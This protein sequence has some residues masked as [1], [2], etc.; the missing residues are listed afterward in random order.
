MHKNL[1][2]EVRN[3]LYNKTRQLQATF[4][5]WDSSLRRSAEALNQE[6]EED[7]NDSDSKSNGGSSSAK[8]SDIST[9]SSSKQLSKTERVV[10]IQ[11]WYLQEEKAYIQEILDSISNFSTSCKF[12]GAASVLKNYNINQA[13]RFYTY[14]DIRDDH[15]YFYGLQVSDK[16]YRVLKSKESEM[17]SV[18][19]HVTRY[20]QH[21]RQKPSINISYFFD[22]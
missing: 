6:D 22:S 12:E 7:D 19:D 17:N 10:K 11:M 21:K 3:L 18:V 1:E 5:V 4:E 20:V 16:S 2:S 14:V 15:V 9:Q 8:S 13:L